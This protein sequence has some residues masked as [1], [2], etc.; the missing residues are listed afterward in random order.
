MDVTEND[1]AADDAYLREKK[2]RQHVRTN[3]QRASNTI[4]RRYPR[5]ETVDS[6]G[7]R[8]QRKDLVDQKALNLELVSGLEYEAWRL[9]TMGK[10]IWQIASIMQ[11]T[12]AQVS[13]W[14][15]DALAQVRAKTAE[16]I[17][18][19]RELELSRTETLLEHY[20]PLALHDAIILERIQQGEPVGIEDFEQP[21]RCAYIVMEL[22]KLRCKIKGL[23]L[24]ETDKAMMPAAE[25]MGWLRTQH[26]FIRDAAQAAPRDVLTLETNEPIDEP[27]QSQTTKDPGDPASIPDAL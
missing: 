15:Q 1:L 18:L 10:K 3:I 7:A 11:T 13:I 27:Q 6:N 26:E 20:M 22:I 5:S 25:V 9:R 4:E 23:T 12:Q 8:K 16:M 21:Q 24:S 17:D 19:D 14:L 2:A